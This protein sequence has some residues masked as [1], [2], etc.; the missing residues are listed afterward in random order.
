MPC[1]P[2]PSWP[3]APLGLACG[4]TPSP[5]VPGS[6][7]ACQGH[8]SHGLAVRADGRPAGRLLRGSGTASYQRALCHCRPRPVNAS[9]K[10]TLSGWA[11][12]DVA[13]VLLVPLINTSLQV[14]A[15]SRPVVSLGEVRPAGKVML[16]PCPTRPLGLSQ[17]LPAFWGKSLPLISPPL[18]DPSCHLGHPSL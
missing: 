3:A 12:A 2:P 15:V 14:P 16:S 5:A 11:A 18:P 10:P 1:V 13:T 4:S 6:R 17:L 8:P 7:A 9:P